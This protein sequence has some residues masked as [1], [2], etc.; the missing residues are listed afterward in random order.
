[1]HV[2]M[3]VYTCQHVNV[4]NS[5]GVYCGPILLIFTVLMSPH[6]IY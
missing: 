6:I 4:E 1:M 5:D 3:F 2:S